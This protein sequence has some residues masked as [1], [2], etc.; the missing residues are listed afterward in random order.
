MAKA[1]NYEGENLLRACEDL[2][3][4]I[5]RP[6]VM[7]G[8]EA[9][10]PKASLALGDNGAD[11]KVT[12]IPHSLIARLCVESLEYPNAGRSTLCAMAAA[13]P[14]TGSDDWKPLLQDVAA[15]R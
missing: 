2:E 11:L 5:V 12:S 14:G 15:D 7:T 6:G 1:W 13:E 9:E 3:Y 8:G 10:F 4:T